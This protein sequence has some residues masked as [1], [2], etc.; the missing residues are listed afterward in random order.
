MNP[1]TELDGMR[2]INKNVTEVLV[3]YMQFDHHW[4]VGGKT[5]DGRFDDLCSTIPEK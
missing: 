4:I 3:V 2:C 5:D 1:K